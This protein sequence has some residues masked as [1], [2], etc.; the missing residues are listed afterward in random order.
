MGVRRHRACSTPLMR[1]RSVLTCRPA[2]IVSPDLKGAQ[3]MSLS[4]RRRTGADRS[5]TAARRK[6]GCPIEVGRLEG[7]LLLTG[8]IT[9]P[10]TTLQ[11]FPNTLNGRGYYTASPET[12]NLLVS[13]P[14]SPNGLTTFYN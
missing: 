5:V 9:P 1:G 8:D 4:T 2:S 14:D 13:D 6:R 7:R 11:V 12:V 10:T 3:K